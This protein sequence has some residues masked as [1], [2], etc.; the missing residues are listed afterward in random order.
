MSEPASVVASWATP[1]PATDV[2]LTRGALWTWSIFAVAIG[3]ATATILGAGATGSGVEDVLALLTIAGF[4]SV[5]TLAITVI[6][7]MLIGLPITIL[8]ARLLR[9]VPSIWP[10]IGA[11][12][13]A[14]TVS[15]VA[16]VLVLQ[17]VLLNSE[18]DFDLDRVSAHII[19]VVL[20][21]GVCS[22][23]G[24]L[25]ALRGHRR[26]TRISDSAATKHPVQESQ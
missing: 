4:V 11:Q 20:C 12:F 25:L 2:N 22:A 21:A 19:G 18:F 7:E 6:P 13:V 24:W 1:L 3:T 9:S 8:F 23:A 26:R 10:H 14:G 5:L 17:V 15:A 16:T